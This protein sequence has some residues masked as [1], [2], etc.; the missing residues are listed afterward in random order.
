GER[1]MFA[2]GNIS[3]T[4]RKAHAL[5]GCCRQLASVTCASAA[6]GKAAMMWR[7]FIAGPAIASGTGSRFSVRRTTGNQPDGG[8]SRPVTSPHR[9][10]VQL[11]E[12]LARNLLDYAA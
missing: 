8:G 10:A 4:L 1:A 3:R 7:G 5:N 6:G 2:V 9:I 12:R 11:A